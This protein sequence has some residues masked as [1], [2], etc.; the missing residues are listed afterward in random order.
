MNLK[1]FSIATF[2]L[3]LCSTIS[4]EVRA[5]FIFEYNGAPFDQVEGTAFTAGLDRI[6]GRFTFSHLGATQA[7]SILLSAT[8][9]GVTSILFDIPDVSSSPVGVVV[10]TNT[11]GGW[12]NGLPTQWDVTLFGNL[13]GDSEEEQ[14]SIHSQIGDLA[15]LDLTSPNGSTAINFQPGSVVAVP[16]PSSL[17]LMLVGVVTALFQRRYK[18]LFRIKLAS[19]A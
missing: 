17:T 13:L 2:A 16:E 1:I 9:N 12:V 7:D 19:C 10:G 4:T 15:A 8:S 18:G 11:F 5:G 3:L 14:L 6:V